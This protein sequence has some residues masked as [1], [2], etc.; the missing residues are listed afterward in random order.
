MLQSMSAPVRNAMITHAKPAQIAR[1][2]LQESDCGNNTCAEEE[3]F[4][5]FILLRAEFHSPNARI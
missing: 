5:V 3:V 2:W 4:R 1:I